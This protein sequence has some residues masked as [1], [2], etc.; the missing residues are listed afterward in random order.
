[1]PFDWN[2][3]AA[4]KDAADVYERVNNLL[5]SMLQPVRQRKDV[6]LTA[7]SQRIVHGG[8]TV[9]RQ[10]VVVLTGSTPSTAII[11]RGAMDDRFVFLHTTADCTVDL[12][13]TDGPA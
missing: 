6:L 7:G 10:I 8:R 5:R 3:N 12:E 2:F 1:M 13:I 9:P 11:T 4:I